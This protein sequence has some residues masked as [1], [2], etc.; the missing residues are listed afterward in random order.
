MRIT[1]NNLTDAKYANRLCY[2]DV[3]PYEIVRFVS[4]T[5]IEVREMKA[6]LD[7]T[8]K[9]ETI[10]GGFC[11]HTVNQRSQRWI[12]TADPTAPVTRIRLSKKRGWRDAGGTMYELTVEPRKFYDYNF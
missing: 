5:T 10:P 4:A 8:W 12:I 6:D 7:P 11:G 1:K 9:P 2:S 3:Q